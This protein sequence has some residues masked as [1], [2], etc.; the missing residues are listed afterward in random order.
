MQHATA[1]ATGPFAFWLNWQHLVVDTPYCASGPVFV[2]ESA[3]APT[4]LRNTVPAQQRSRLL[5]VRAYD[6]AGWMHAAEVAEGTQLERL[7]KRFFADPWIDYLHAHNARR[8]C[9]A[10]RI[11]RG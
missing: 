9:Y 2:R 11:D 10:R 7:L 3:R 6:A 4:V 5:S 8:G 1:R